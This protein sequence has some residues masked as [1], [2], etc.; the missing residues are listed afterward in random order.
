MRHTETVCDTID[1]LG[2]DN[3]ILCCQ[4]KLSM[5]YDMR[6]KLKGIEGKCF[7]FETKIPNVNHIG[8]FF[9]F[10]LG[11]EDLSLDLDLMVGLSDLTSHTLR[12]LREIV[13][14]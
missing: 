8:S 13:K 2:V 1:T 7:G 11:M 10:C 9:L 3:E 12:E 4:S 6:W 14:N 5:C